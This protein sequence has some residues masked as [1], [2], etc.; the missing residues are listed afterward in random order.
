MFSRNFIA[1]STSVGE[2]SS[3]VYQSQI[4]SPQISRAWHALVADIV[5]IILVWHLQFPRDMLV[6]FLWGCH[7]DATRKLLPW[8]FELTSVSCWNVVV[9]AW[10]LS[11]QSRAVPM[12]MQKNAGV[13]WNV[14]AK[15]DYTWNFTFNHLNLLT[16]K[17]C[18]SHPV[19]FTRF[20]H[21]YNIFMA[22]FNCNWSI[23]N[24]W[25]FFYWIRI[26]IHYVSES[27][28]VNWI[29][30]RC[31][32]VVFQIWSDHFMMAEK[33]LAIARGSMHWNLVL[34]S[35]P[36]SCQI[37]QCNLLCS[38]LSQPWWTRSLYST[39]TLPLGHMVFQLYK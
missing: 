26:R 14:F 1:L 39:H 6:T 20:V 2:R 3:S 18:C 17:P 27:R 11:E 34:W 36:V 19:C 33:D 32:V 30:P 22:I 37:R 23:Q 4:R 13:A 5:A 24:T 25:H 8:N 21:H 15:W 38:D 29:S 16:I 9:S 12:W 7:E 10:K 28:F 31:V 35:H